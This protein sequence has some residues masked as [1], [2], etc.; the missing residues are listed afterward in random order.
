MGAKDYREGPP[1]E[2]PR[3]GSVDEIV[4]APDGSRLAVAQSGQRAC[5]FDLATRAETVLTGPAAAA[6]RIDFSPNGKLLGLL[7]DSPVLRLW[8][9]AGNREVAAWKLT[10][11]EPGHFRFAPRGGLLAATCGEDLHLID[12]AREAADRVVPLGGTPRALAFAPGGGTSPSPWPG[13]TLSSWTGGSGKS[14]RSTRAIRNI[15]WSPPSR[16]PR[17]GP[18]WP[19]APARRTAEGWCASGAGRA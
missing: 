6:R 1:L 8:D 3:Y 10:G 14:G 2:I 11:K 12:R 16:S 5:V 18:Y 19:S 17:T 13:A 15:P 4:F 9:P 7:G